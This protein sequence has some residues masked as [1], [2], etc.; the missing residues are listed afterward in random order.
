M[1]DLKF[2]PWVSGFISAHKDRTALLELV[3]Y[4][5]FVLRTAETQH[6][7]GKLNGEVLSL[8]SEYLKKAEDERVRD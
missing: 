3:Q 5:E 4:L 8:K 6:D 2:D 1:V 7:I